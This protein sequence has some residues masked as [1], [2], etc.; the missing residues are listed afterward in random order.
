MV[1]KALGDQD[2][3]D[4]HQKAQSQ[5]FDGGVGLDKLA[6]AFGKQHHQPQGN[7]HSRDHDAH[8]V[9]HANRGDDG[10]QRKHQVNQHDLHDGGSQIGF[11]LDADRRFLAFQGVVNFARAFPNQ[12]QTAG[13]QNQVSPR[14]RLF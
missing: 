12:K 2:H 9:D 8:I 5:H 13:Q 4:H 3:A 6:N 14:E 10:V 11:G 7:Q 1:A